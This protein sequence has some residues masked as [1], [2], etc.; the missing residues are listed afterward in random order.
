MFS[1]SAAPPSAATSSL[2]RLP[3]GPR[4]AAIR[5]AISGGYKGKLYVY[6]KRAASE[7]SSY[8]FSHTGSFG[9][10]TTQVYVAAYSGCI[11][12]GDPVDVFSQNGAS[13]GSTATYTGVTTTVASTKLVLLGHNWD[14][15]GTLTPPTGTTE[16][17]DGVV[18]SADEDRA[19]AGATGDRTQ[20]LASS[21][22][23]GAFFVAL[24]P[25]AGTGVYTLPAVAGSYAITGIDARPRKQ[26]YFIGVT[27][28][29]AVTAT[30]I[31]LTEPAGV[32]DGDLLVA[33][34]ASRTTATTAIT[35]TG[36][37]AVGSQNNNNTLT[38]GS[39]IGSGTMLYQV[40]AGTPDLTFVIPAGISVAMGSMVAYGGTAATTP[41][42]VS[43]AVTAAAGYGGQRHRPHHHAGRRP[44]R[45]H[46]G[47][48]AG[49]GVV[50]L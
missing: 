45:R 39:A 4:S 19:S 38:T 32:A 13:T 16:R 42:D 15:T 30:A 35:N 34:F 48:R 44:D 28:A 40:R 17:F 43:T 20:T 23:W 29:A 2:C 33:C 25:A 3:D 9:D 27:N 5:K 10:L 21:A 12:T 41:L 8:V 7:G 47:G 49:S 37:T 50:E 46:G 31:T 26:F 24:K 14:G 22:P 1:P 18:Y 6:W 36:W 11:A